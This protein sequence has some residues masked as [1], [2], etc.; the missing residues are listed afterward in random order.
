MKC[1]LNDEEIRAIYKKIEPEENSEN[2]EE[3]KVKEKAPYM[4][5]AVEK[6]LGLIGY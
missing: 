3:E 1:S 6:A 4:S 2:R 5:L